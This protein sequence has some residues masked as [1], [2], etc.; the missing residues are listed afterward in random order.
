MSFSWRYKPKAFS[1][2]ELVVAALLVSGLSVAL[3]AGLKSMQ[4][5]ESVTQNSQTFLNQKR[6]LEKQLREDVY[7]AV[8]IRCASNMCPP[9]VQVQSGMQLLENISRN[10]LGGTNSTFELDPNNSPSVTNQSFRIFRYRDSNDFG[11]RIQSFNADGPS[12]PNRSFSIST[13]AEDSA[14][15]AP[16]VGSLYLVVDLQQ[17]GNQSEFLSQL[18]QV[19][20]VQSQTIS[21]DQVSVL[22]P[23]INLTELGYEQS[24]YLVGPIDIIEW[25]TDEEG[26]LWRR[27]LRFSSANVNELA[28][29]NSR[30]SLIL[31]SFLSLQANS[32]AATTNDQGFVV[33]F[34]RLR[35]MLT[36]SLD[37]TGP[38]SKTKS[39]G[40]SFTRERSVL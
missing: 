9:E 24:S 19:T 20:S 40:M 1:L 6:L 27:R 3:L 26:Q 33:N 5:S 38:T 28:S 32:P 34:E 25:S 29:A 7:R 36:F 14:C 31:K 12:L 37:F 15:Q 22:N 39:V 18:I 13:Q 17:Q 35:L 4:S 30:W 23:Q 8:E 10:Q 11:C 21:Y 2:T 16:L